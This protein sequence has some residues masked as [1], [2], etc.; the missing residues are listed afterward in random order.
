MLVLWR[1]VIDELCGQDEAR[2][3]DAVGGAPQTAGHG[4]E[5]VPEAVEV[6]EGR[7]QRRGLDVA[8]LDEPADEL[9]EGGQR[10]V[11]GADGAE[12]GGGGGRREG[13]VGAPPGLRGHH[14]LVAGDDGLGGRREVPD[15]TRVDAAGDELLEGGGLELLGGE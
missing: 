4:L 6:D 14:V 5:T 8:R 15:H 9:L 11:R 3:E 12:L 7:E 10:G 1:D 2:E 13:G